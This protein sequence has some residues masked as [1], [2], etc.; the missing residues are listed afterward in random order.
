MTISHNAMT[1][2]FSGKQKI[3]YGKLPTVTSR[4]SA[5][6]ATADIVIIPAT[7]TNRR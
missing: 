1:R 5:K 7:I 3:W 2:I 6:S 4:I